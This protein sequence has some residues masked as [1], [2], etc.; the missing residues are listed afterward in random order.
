MNLHKYT[1][2]AHAHTL[3]IFIGILSLWNG[4]EATMLRSGSWHCVYF[5]LIHIQREQQKQKENFKNYNSTKPKT[6]NT[7]MSESFVQGSI[8]GTCGII[9]R[10]VEGYMY[11]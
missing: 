8:A 5:S 3:H 11:S 9:P 2:L 4:I 6:Q 1:T 10:D 7:I